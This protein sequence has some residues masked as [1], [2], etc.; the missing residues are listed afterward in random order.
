MCIGM[1]YH[2]EKGFD[3]IIVINTVIQDLELDMF[4]DARLSMLH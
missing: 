3:F 1:E 2:L 4:V